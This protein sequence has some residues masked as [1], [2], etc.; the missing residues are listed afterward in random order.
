M[1]H[2]ILIGTMTGLAGCVG[3]TSPDTR[4]VVG[5]I[6]A[7][8]PFPTIVAPDSVQAG[9]WFTA[10]VYSFGSSSC[11]IPDG[12]GLTLG[13]AEARVI[14]YD[15]VPADR[16]AVCTADISPRPH[17]VELHFTR[18]GEASILVQ[19]EVIEGTSGRRVPGEVNKDV[20]VLP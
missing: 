3:P 4:R 20:F 6:D 18:P 5:L 7:N 15:R 1:R 13:A 19:G 14:P 17:V 16:G 10:T 11:T 12:V 9:A 8:G 2:L